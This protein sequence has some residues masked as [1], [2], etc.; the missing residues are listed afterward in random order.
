[1]KASF[2][3]GESLIFI[4]RSIGR[5]FASTTS[6]RDHSPP[7]FRASEHTP[8]Q[9]RNSANPYAK[10]TA[11]TRNHHFIATLSAT[12]VTLDRPTVCVIPQMGEKLLAIGAA[13]K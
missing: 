7:D 1:L 12:G 11:T 13:M 10:I 9:I 3:S 8:F 5:Y 4:R 6:E 2:R